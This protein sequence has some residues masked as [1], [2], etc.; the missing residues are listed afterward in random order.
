MTLSLL[1]Y[2]SLSTIQRKLERIWKQFGEGKKRT[3]AVLDCPCCAKKGVVRLDKHLQDRHL[4]TSSDERAALLREAKRAAIVKELRDLRLS[5]PSVPLLSELDIDPEPLVG[6]EGMEE[7]E[8][9]AIAGPSVSDPEPLVGGEGMEEEEDQA[10]AGPSLSGTSYHMDQERPGPSVSLEAFQRLE[11]RLSSLERSHALLLKKWRSLQAAPAPVAPTSAQKGEH[12]GKLQNADFLYESLVEDYR[13]FR[14]GAR[15]R[16]KDIDNAK[17]SASHSLRFCRYMAQGVAA[18]CL[19]RSVRFLNRLDHLRGYPTYLVNKGYKST[20]IKNMITN[21]IMFLR[22]VSKRFPRQTRLRPAEASNIEYELQ[23]I[24]HPAGSACSQAKGPQEKVSSILF[25]ADQ[26]D[27]R[28]SVTFLDR[29]KR[30]IDEIICRKDP[31]ELHGLG[32]GYI[33]CYLAIVTGHR[34]VVFHH[35]TKESVQE[36][37]SWKS[38]TRFQV[39]VDDH[40][41]SRTFGQASLVL[42]RHE[43][44][45]LRVLATG[46]VCTEECREVDN[47]FHSPSG[48]PIRQVSELINRAWAAAGLGGSIS[49]NKIRSSV[50][51]QANDHLTEE[52]RRR[53]ARAM[54]HDP[55]TASKFYVALPNGESQYRDRL[56]RMKALCLASNTRPDRHTRPAVSSSSESEGPEPA[57]RD[58]P[59]SSG[60]ELASP[61]PNPSSPEPDPSSPEP[62]TPPPQPSTADRQPWTPVWDCSEGTTASRKRRRMLFPADEED[63]EPRALPHPIKQCTVDCDRLPSGVLHFYAN[64]IREYPAQGPTSVWILNLSL[65]RDVSNRWRLLS[66]LWWGC[67]SCPV[68]CSWLV[69]YYVTLGFPCCC[70]QYPW[71]PTGGDHSLCVIYFTLC[72][73]GQILPGPGGGY[74]KC[75]FPVRGLLFFYPWRYYLEV[76]SD[77]NDVM[78]SLSQLSNVRIQWFLVVLCPW[79]LRSGA[80][81]PIGSPGSGGH[82]C[83]PAGATFG[84]HGAEP[85][86][87]PAVPS[88][89]WFLMGASHRYSSPG[90]PTAPA[91]PG[92]APGRSGYLVIMFL[93][94]WIPAGM[95]MLVYN[96][97]GVWSTGGGGGVPG[98]EPSH[99]SR[100]NSQRRWDGPSLALGSSLPLRSALI[101]KGISG[102]RSSCGGNHSEVPLKGLDWDVSPLFLKSSVGI[103]LR[104]LF[105]SSPLVFK[106][107]TLSAFVLKECCPPVKC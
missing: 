66:L 94:A 15:T 68:M 24:Q 3:T 7:E 50:S 1:S 107:W 63:E 5:D 56:L 98:T 34:A 78:E 25:T 41:T 84:D 72:D 6:G 67:N 11:A 93:T 62:F 91:P 60:S 105:I 73:P 81:T 17:Q 31:D 82:R 22:H 26:L 74:L 39:L 58:S 8:D 103:K 85:K 104:P 21:V 88:T 10:I 43:F 29:A 76:V 101:K 79:V 96:K 71:L 38:G 57:Y 18:D 80:R 51:T 90:V 99:T 12:V 89:S 27:P 77:F 32:M 100:W 13:L 4:K 53:V 54:C 49:F 35:V 47:I 102:G 44:N 48:G 37:D 83:G 33:L 16:T 61:E 40:K 42:E 23:R 92:R 20:T 30:A 55:A 14:L 97:T 28:D 65:H 2:V 70:W 19:T 75:Q 69:S 95:S 59:D 9:Q 46:E 52:E 45:W 106:L 64:V 86:C 36:A 87:E